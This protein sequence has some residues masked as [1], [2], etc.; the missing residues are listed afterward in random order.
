MTA[1]TITGTTVQLRNPANT[2]IAA[3]VSYNATTRTATLT[4]SS[5]LANGTT[6]TATVV[7]GS[8]G[9]KDLAGNALATTFSWSF[10]TAAAN[11]TTLGLTSIGSAVDDGNSNFLNGSK[12]TTSTGGN[13]VSMS[14]YV[15][16]IDSG[17]NNRQY[18][19]AIYTHNTTTGK[20]GTLVAKTASGTLKANAWNT[21][22][23]TATLSPNTSYWLLY[24]TNGRTTSVNNMYFN[25][26]TAGQGVFST[27]SVTFGTWPTTF[28]ASTLTSGVYSLYATFGP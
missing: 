4:P 23:I 21:L 27:N 1:S 5:A 28:P 17:A 15:G 12:V 2:V 26:G 10:T 20:P 13:I 22:P 25:N 6:Y 19:L 16:P 24:N 18:Q 9:V 8:S 14:V 3:T 7:G 11:G